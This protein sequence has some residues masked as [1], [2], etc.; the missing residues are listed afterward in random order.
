[1]PFYAAR[2][3]GVARNPRRRRPGQVTPF[4]DIA[5]DDALPTSIFGSFAMLAAMRRASSR[6][7]SLA[8]DR[9]PGS[10]FALGRSARHIA[11][12]LLFQG[13]FLVGAPRFE[14][15]TPSPPD[16]CAN[17][18]ALRSVDAAGL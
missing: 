4:G 17:R 2:Y 14:L 12:K 18:A 9:L 15:G 5:H 11:E 8:A 13:V 7:S 6:V 10:V 16:W 1:M 3:R